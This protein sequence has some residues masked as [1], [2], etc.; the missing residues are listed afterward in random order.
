MAKLGLAKHFEQ[1][2]EQ[3]A[4]GDELIETEE[5]ADKDPKQVIAQVETHA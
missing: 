3:T 1:L 4:D 2:N 5:L